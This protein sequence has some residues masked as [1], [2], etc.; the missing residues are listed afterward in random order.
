VF[1]NSSVFI[2]TIGSYVD[3]CSDLYQKN[4]QQS[5][6]SQAP[7]QQPTFSLQEYRSSG[8]CRYM[9]YTAIRKL[10]SEQFDPTQQPVAICF[11]H[12]DVEKTLTKLRS[13]RESK[14]G[15]VVQGVFYFMRAATRDGKQG[16]DNLFCV[17]GNGGQVYVDTRG[18]YTE[19]PSIKATF[20]KLSSKRP[21]VKLVR[22]DGPE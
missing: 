7:I 4:L 12:E 17:V 13:F 15:T 11:Y 1:N 5:L 22:D 16:W 6:N 3:L 19:F 18:K 8:F 9:A 20:D 14:P 21:F 10:S 2:N